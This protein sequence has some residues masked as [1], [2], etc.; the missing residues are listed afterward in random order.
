MSKQILGKIGL[1]PKG[2]YNDETSYK[3]LDFVKYN[4]SSF[5]ALKDNQGVTPETDNSIWQLLAIKGEK[6]DKPS[7]GI[8]YNTKQ[9]KENFKNQVVNDSKTDLNDYMASLKS[10]LNDYERQKETRLNDYTSN[11]IKDLNS[12][13]TSLLKDITDETTSKT[14]SF[15]S[16]YTDKLSSFNTNVE[17][18]TQDFDDNCISKTNELNNVISN[19]LND[20]NNATSEYVKKTEYATT[21]NGGTIKKTTSTNFNVLAS[22]YV[23]CD[24]QTYEK[25]KSLGDN[26]FISKGTLENVLIENIGSIDTILDSINGEV[27]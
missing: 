10:D 13:T 26:S 8:D 18:K 27:I 19:T 17:T 24:V 4:G 6:G 1:I 12:T 16:N 21:T 23:T 2:E 14:E 3:R 25:Y 22:G 20:F 11:M 7:N 15:N 5:V 9:E